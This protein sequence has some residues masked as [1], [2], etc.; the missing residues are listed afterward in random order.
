MLKIYKPILENNME[1][2]DEQLDLNLDKA[3]DARS[4]QA[5][6]IGGR[7]AD[8][9]PELNSPEFEAMIEKQMEEKRAECIKR[10][11]QAL[12]SNI[13]SLML[14]QSM[15]LTDNEFAAKIHKS[16]LE[17]LETM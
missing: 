13:I 5:Q 4:A 10:A 14:Q 1:K 12:A 16:C 2:C 9:N 17:V 7:L 11:N 8:F 6:G 3:R 15:P